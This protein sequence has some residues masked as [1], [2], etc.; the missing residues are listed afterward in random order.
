MVT[1]HHFT[2]P[3]WLYERGGW[4]GEDAVDHFCRYVAY[5]VEALGDLVPL[6]CTINE[7]MVY[8]TY[9]HLLGLW[10]PGCG[11]PRAAYRVLR[12]MVR[13]HVKAY[14]II[15]RRW[16]QARVG[17]AKH[18]HLFDAAHPGCWI[19]GAAAKA[20]DYFFNETPLMAFWHG[21]MPS[22]LHRSSREKGGAWLDFLGLNYYSRSMVAFDPRHGEEFFIRRFPNPASDFSMEGWGEIYPHGLY[23][24]LKRL[25]A[26]GLPLY[27]TEFGVPDND[28]T[29][30]PRFIVEHVAALHRALK[31]GIPVRGAY[32]WSLVD[33]F[34]W[35][36]GWRA[37]FGL[38]HLDPGT[39]ERRPRRSAYVY[40]RIANENALDQ[41]L[42][43]D[44]APDLAPSLF[45]GQQ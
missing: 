36:E 1:L 30:R 38:V 20:V 12:N 3:L 5:V 21:R 6:W 43:S 17:Y 25:S 16:P 33:N 23:R 2:L 19:D 7:P 31:E 29:L 14:E 8:A 11:G 24:A 44:L 34:E 28:D 40:Q 22:L 45:D 10:P 9:G 27:V 42:V 13:A 37:R 35:H 32:F 15:H 4:E 39:Q 18:I 41:G 26:Y